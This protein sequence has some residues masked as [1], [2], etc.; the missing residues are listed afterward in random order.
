MATKRHRNKKLKKMGTTKNCWKVRQPKSDLILRSPSPQP[1][2]PGRGR[3]FSYLGRTWSR[4]F[5]H[6]NGQFDRED[7]KSV[8]QFCFKRSR[9]VHPLLGERVG[10]RAT[11]PLYLVLF[12]LCLFVANLIYEKH[13]RRFN[14]LRLH[15]ADAFERVSQ[16]RQFF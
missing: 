14:R 3:A 16:S 6:R 15:G 8:T 11:L 5:N 13:Q 10:V 9:M 4:G 1:S 12:L 2:P 7:R